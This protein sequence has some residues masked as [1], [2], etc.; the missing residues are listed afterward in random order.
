[1]RF[2]PLIF[3]GNCEYVSDYEN[4]E[5]ARVT[6]MQVSLS[7]VATF[8]T[9]IVAVAGLILSIYNFYVDRKDKSPRLVAKISN[10]FLTHGPELSDVMLL[11]EV[12]NPS[13]KTIKIVAVEIVWKKRKIV[14]INGI[15]G[16]NKVPFE[17]KPGDKAMFWTPIREIARSLKKEGSIGKESV[18][19]CFRTAIDSEYRSKWFTVDVHEWMKR[20]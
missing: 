3:S 4:E 14:F 20:D 5:H 11:L 13:E 7:D 12:I 15:E 17:L 19:A 16:T 9:A 2:S 10:G 18:K 8:L 1:M 6:I